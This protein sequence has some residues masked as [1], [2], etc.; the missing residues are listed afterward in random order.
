MLPKAGPPAAT[1]S[2]ATNQPAL[3]RK[4]TYDTTIPRPIGRFYAIQLTPGELGWC[5]ILARGARKV[6]TAKR[7]REAAVAQA[8]A[9]EATH[10]ERRVAEHRAAL[11]AAY[12]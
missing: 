10:N 7:K 8:E 6:K 4:C 1:T 9:E 2:A 3:P 5:G 11:A 12:R